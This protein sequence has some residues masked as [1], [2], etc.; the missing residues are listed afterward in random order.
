MS[1]AVI[2]LG[3]NQ[4]DRLKYFVAAAREIEKS[5][6]YILRVAPLYRSDAYGFEEQ[7]YFYNSVLI[8]ETNF[9]PEKLLISLKKIEDKIG[10]KK[11]KRWGPR[12]IDLDIIFYNSIVLDSDL[13]TI[14]HPDFQNRD[15]VLKPLSDI[16]PARI[17]PGNQQTIQ[18]LLNK[19]KK[20]NNLK[21]IV[22]HW[23][24]DGAEI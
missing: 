17:N 6:G 7:P 9:P 15:F 12:E 24:N 20:R 22:N 18:K 10:R 19:C 21:K 14:P 1:R 8:V 13:L 16:D 2:S 5:V 23:Y 11:R 4:G 3:S